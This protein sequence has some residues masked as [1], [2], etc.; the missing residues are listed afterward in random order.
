V[1]FGNIL[2][3]IPQ[4]AAARQEI[5]IIGVG[6]IKGIK[7]VF[8]VVKTDGRDLVIGAL[9]RE[10]RQGQQE[11]GEKNVLHNMWVR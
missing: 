7:Q 2:F 5:S 11:K 9:L 4:K 6:R 3:R 1:L 10:C 8:Q